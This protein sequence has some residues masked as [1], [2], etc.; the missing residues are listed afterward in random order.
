MAYASLSPPNYSGKCL[1][2]LE[3]MLKANV[4]RRDT[5]LRPSYSTYLLV[6]KACWSC[7][8][9]RCAAKTFDLM[10]GY[11]CHD[12]MD[13]V[14]SDRP[15]FD[16]RSEGRSFPPNV[17]TVSLMVRTAVRAGN[18]AHIR[19]VLRLTHYLG[20]KDLFFNK[21][22][23]DGSSQSRKATENRVFFSLKL[24][25]AV[26]E[27][28]KKILRENSGVDKPRPDD[29]ARWKEL[30]QDAAAISSLAPLFLIYPRSRSR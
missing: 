15:R 16:A 13:G 25:D 1:G 5:K 30:E 14:V 28:I 24:V 19:Q 21:F 3:W 27:G 22:A 12:F 26:R 9:W 11:H 8:D 7:G 18:R 2:L 17:E 10:T 4:L 20:M 23:P 6:L 29:L